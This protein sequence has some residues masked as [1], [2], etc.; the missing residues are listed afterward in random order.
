MKKYLAILITVCFGLFFQQNVFADSNPTVTF[1]GGVSVPSSTS[2]F[3]DCDASCYENYSY[4]KITSASAPITAFYSNMR[5]YFV[6][7]DVNLDS[8]QV[9]LNLSTETYYKIDDVPIKNIRFSQNTTPTY[10]FTAELVPELGPQPEPCPEPE[11]C[12][13]CETPPFVQ[14]VVDAFWKYHVAFAA[15]VPAILVI[16]LVYRLIKGRLR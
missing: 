13:D 2:W 15:A 11:P 10:T 14:I 3:P 6:P 4:L 9:Y 8:A 16:F 12:P 1:T 7:V 5:I